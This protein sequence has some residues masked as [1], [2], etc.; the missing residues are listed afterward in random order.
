MR[1]EL[2]REG[3]ELEYAAVRDPENW[4]AEQPVSPLERGMGLLAARVEGVRLID[5]LRF[6]QP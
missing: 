2:Q 4:T 6:D 5:N 1:A 3:I